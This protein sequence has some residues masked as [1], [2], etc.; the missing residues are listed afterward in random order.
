[1]GRRRIDDDFLIAGLMAHGSIKNAAAALKVSSATFTKRMNDADFIKKYQAARADVLR[2]AVNK[3][4]AAV[5]D[6]V[7]V[8]HDILLDDT[9]TSNTTRIAAARAILEYSIKLSDSLRD[10]EPVPE[11]TDGLKEFDD[12]FSAALAASARDMVEKY[13]SE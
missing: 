7:D 4:G 5:E 2:G 13:R 3:A 12:A 6:A 10:A 9:A 11:Q 1:M 8:L